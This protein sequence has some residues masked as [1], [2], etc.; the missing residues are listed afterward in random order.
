MAIKHQFFSTSG[1]I[2]W[3]KTKF[4]QFHDI[5]GSL[6]MTPDFK[7]TEIFDIKG[8]KHGKKTLACYKPGFVIFAP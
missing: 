4:I 7:I 3:R 6:I 2:V 1:T 5:R 8:K